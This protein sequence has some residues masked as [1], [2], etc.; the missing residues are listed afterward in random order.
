MNQSLLEENQDQVIKPKK[1]RKSQKN[2]EN[3]QK[4]F[5]KINTLL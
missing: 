5:A 1:G 4:L 2:I 3:S